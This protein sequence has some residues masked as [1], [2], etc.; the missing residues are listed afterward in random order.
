MTYDQYLKHKFI[1]I[2]RWEDY[3]GLSGWSSVIARVF[4]KRGGAGVAV[5]E[6]DWRCSLPLWRWEKGPW[7]KGCRQPVEL[8]KAAFPCCPRWSSCGLP[9]FSCSLS[10]ALLISGPLCP[11]V[12]PLVP[13]LC[14]C[15][16][17]HWAFT[18]FHGCPFGCLSLLLFDGTFL[19]WEPRFTQLAR[20]I[21]EQVF[22]KESQTGHCHRQAHLHWASQF[23][24]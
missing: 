24:K 2:L 22:L 6:R 17:W 21:A 8:E 4:K 9:A 16:L 14:S 13:V 18:V 11:R 12:S 3:P 10:T 7:A 15:G 19:G 20:R 23:V 5:P 1:P